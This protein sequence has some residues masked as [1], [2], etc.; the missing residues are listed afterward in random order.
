MTAFKK[1]DPRAFL[2]RERLAPDRT[3][4]LAALATLAGPP[5][6]NEIRTIPSPVYQPDYSVPAAK[7]I[8]LQR[9]DHTFI[10]RLDQ[11]SKNQNLTPTPAKVAKVAKVQNPSRNFSNFSGPPA[12]Q[13]ES[14][15][16]RGELRAL[17]AGDH[18]DT[19]TKHDTYP[20][21]SALA[22]LPA[23]CPAYVSE[24][25]WRQAITDA[26]AFAT[27]WGPEAQALGWTE[28]E[29][30]GLHPVPEQPAPNYDR[31]A[32]LDDMGLIWLLRSRP[33]V[34]L[35]ETTAAIQ[36]ATAVLTYR[37][38][39]MPALGPVGDSLEDWG[40]T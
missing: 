10:H 13:I 35:T 33:L 36:G 18:G 24:D 20:Y 8:E 22:A 17:T 11:L 39:N 28:P 21:A 2:E 14:K 5:P 25:R 12:E 34:A 16:A 3:E 19:E 9:D 6:E 32:R 31:L 27:E 38:I 1:F 15:R 30:L 7:S 37:K 4:T 23:Q 29:L 40:A 26:T